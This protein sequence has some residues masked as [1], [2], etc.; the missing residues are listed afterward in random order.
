[1]LDEI[2][3]GWLVDPQVAQREHDALQKQIEA[4]GTEKTPEERLL[5]VLRCMER[6][7]YADNLH[8]TYA[9]FL[10]T[11]LSCRA[12][13]AEMPSELA[14]YWISGAFEIIDK[15]CDD[16][17]YVDLDD[18]PLTELYIDTDMIDWMRQTITHAASREANVRK[19]ADWRQIQPLFMAPR[20]LPIL[21]G[22]ER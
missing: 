9:E 11:V 21:D 7:G 18:V 1:M 6:D 19:E 12:V 8:V 14:D 22:T 17:G 16:F 3:T 5:T 20:S 13:D 15:I 2:V 10:E 4:T